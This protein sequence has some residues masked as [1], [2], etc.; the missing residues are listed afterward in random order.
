MFPQLHSHAIVSSGGSNQTQII[1]V[2]RYSVRIRRNSTC[3]S[4]VKGVLARR[5]RVVEQP[6]RRGAPLSQKLV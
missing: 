5:W 2:V 3:H 1:N 4:D 6:R